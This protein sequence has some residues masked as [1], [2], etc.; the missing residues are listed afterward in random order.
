MNMTT[1]I[2]NPFTA[3]VWAG[4][5]SG[6][7]VI[8]SAST[9]ERI[10]QVD[11]PDQS[12][13]EQLIFTDRVGTSLGIA[14]GV[15]A[16][17]RGGNVYLINALTGSVVFEVPHANAKLIQLSNDKSLWVQ[18][19]SEISLMLFPFENPIHCIVQTRKGSDVNNK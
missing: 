19:K 6:K 13:V 5:E 2:S 1:I 7:I 14:A 17:T 9:Y 15:W 18:Q 4:G 11:L 8:L 12:Q 16:R 10:G 3:T